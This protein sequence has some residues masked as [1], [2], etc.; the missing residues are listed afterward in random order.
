M[1]ILHYACINEWYEV[2]IMILDKMTE[3][4]INIID[5]YNET[6]LTHVCQNKWLDIANKIIHKITHK[7]LNH[8]NNS[9]HSAITL[10]YDNE[11]IE[12]TNIMIPKMN[13]KN[14]SFLLSNLCSKKNINAIINLI[15][16]I[17]NESINYNKNILCIACK[18][19][20]TDIIDMLLP[21]CN[22]Q[23]I[24]QYYKLLNS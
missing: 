16:I 19:N 18:Y 5:K 3:Y 24:C 15:P 4:S 17:S 10:A 6:I 12:I 7:T 2:V 23:T 22:E 14:I 20:L 21:K 11:W 1:S 9:N 8:I 13:D